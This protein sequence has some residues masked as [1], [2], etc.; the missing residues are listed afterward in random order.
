ML[1]LNEIFAV[2][3]E[4]SKHVLVFGCLKSL[5]LLYLRGVLKQHARCGVLEKEVSTPFCRMTS[6]DA[7][8]TEKS[9]KNLNCS[10]CY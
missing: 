1:L 4:E 7:A 3:G 5:Y 8:A 10:E 2:W 9:I 6:S